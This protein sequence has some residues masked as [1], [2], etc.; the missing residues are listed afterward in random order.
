VNT[1]KT[2]VVI[3]SRGKI[4]KKPKLHFG[5]NEIDIVDDYLY[6]GVTFNYNGSFAKAIN[7]QI[8]QAKRALYSLISKFRK[9]YLPV[10]I[11]SH[12]IDKCIIPILLYGAEVWGFT[13]TNQVEIFHNQI[14]KQILHVHKYTSN[15]IALGELG[16]SPL[17]GLIKQRMLNIWARIVNGK[18]NKISS[19]MYKLARTRYENSNYKPK[20]LTQIQKCLNELGLGYVWYQTSFNPDWFKHTIRTSYQN[21][22][23]QNWHST[24]N[25]SSPCYSYKDM[26]SELKLEKYLLLLTPRFSVPLCRFRAGNHK[27]PVITGRFSGLERPMRKCN[28]CHSNEVGDEFHYVFK[29]SYFNSERSNLI[30]KEFLTVPDAI[31]LRKLFQT[32]NTNQ[33]LQLSKL[34]TLIMQKFN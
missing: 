28:L 20:W 23:K 4:R 1:E 25:E 17:D 7:K 3:F 14:C 24:L 12:L 6:L 34:V 32:N 27:L 2:K 5:Q 10:D 15:T 11:Q 21:M 13:D 16:R 30:S 31:K 26:K 8:S 29:C 18:E 33:L 22:V 19:L 9:L